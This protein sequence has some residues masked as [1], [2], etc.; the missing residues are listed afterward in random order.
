ML[1]GIGSELEFATIYHN[2]LTHRS[3]WNMSDLTI[4][5]L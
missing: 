2:T 4:R 5:S 1:E 3:T